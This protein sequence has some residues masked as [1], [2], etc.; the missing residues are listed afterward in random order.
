MGLF[1]IWTVTKSPCNKTTTH[2]QS[3]FYWEIPSWE[4]SHH[5]SPFVRRQE[6]ES[7]IFRT[8]HGGILICFLVPQEGKFLG[9]AH[10]EPWIQTP[11]ISWLWSKLRRGLTWQ[12]CLGSIIFV[13]FIDAGVVI[14]F[15]CLTILLRFA[16]AYVF[17]KVQGST[18]F[19]DLEFG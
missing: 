15:R 8:S 11:I 3:E 5:I 17:D 1:P 14:F 2:N 4:R 7:M 9:W 6:L 13:V 18:Q 19:S 16:K 10:D 12:P